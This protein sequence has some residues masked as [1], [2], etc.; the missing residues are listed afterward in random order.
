MP[1]TWRTVRVFISST[2]RDMYGEREEL[3]K[4]VFPQ[5]RK[6]CEQRGV[7]WGEVDLRWGV[8][9]E[10]KAEGKVLPICLEE[11][12]RCRPY[13]IGIL[14]EHYGWIPDEIPQDVSRRE[15][16][17][18]QHLHHSVT[19]LEILH[20]VLNNPEMAKHAFFYFRDAEASREVEAELAKNPDYQPESEDSQAK[21][22]TLKEKIEK[23][24]FPVRKDFRD[25][26]V[27]GELI[28]KDLTAVIDRLYPAD[29]APDTLDR[30]VMEHEAYADRLT[31]V[32]IERKGY[33][34][35]LNKHVSGSGAPLVVL[36]ESGVG[37]SA[38]LANWALKYRE[39]LNNKNAS[40]RKPLLLM[41]FIGASPYSTDWA[42]MLRRIM[43]ELKRHFNIRE[44]IPDK[45]D[46]LRTAF[47]N[48]LHMAAAKGR[49]ILILDALNQLEDRDGAPD[50]VWLPPHIPENIRLILTTLPG[51]P[52]DDLQK[53]GWPTLEVSPLDRDERET[54]IKQY[55]GQYTKSLSQAQVE[56]IA[57]VPQTANPLYLRSLLEE[58]RVYGDHATLNKRI[59]HYLTADTISDLYSR[60]LRR[61][62]EDYEEERPGL[63]KDAMSLLW[64]ARRGLSES[65]LME[66]LGTEEMPLPRATW[67]PLFLAA[68]Q[69]LVSRS[70]LITFGHDY[71]RQ[72]VQN[73]FLRNPGEQ[74]AAHTRLA[75]YYEKQELGPRKVDEL[76]WQLVQVKSWKRLY[77][78][79][80]HVAFVF[81]ALAR[82]NDGYNEALKYW[83][84][85]ENN[86]PLRMIDGYKNAIRDSGSLAESVA[87]HDYL[88]CIS[89]LLISFGYYREAIQIQEKIVEYSHIND[90]KKGL[91]SSLNNI[92]QYY[93]TLAELD[94][95]WSLIEEAYSVCREL[96]DQHG[97][98]MALNTKAQI[99][100]RRGKLDEALKLLEEA[101]H[102]CSREGMP[103]GLARTLL[104]Q[105]NIL[106]DKRN[107]EESL[108]IYRRAEQ[109]YLGTGNYGGVAACI[110]N[111]A[112][113][114]T[115]KKEYDNAIR[116][117][118]KEEK[119]FREIG[120]RKHLYISLRLQAAC[121]KEK[122]DIPKAISLLQ[123]SE[124]ICEQ[125]GDNQGLADTLLEEAVLFVQKLDKPE[126]ALPLI[127]KGQKIG[128][129]LNNSSLQTRY[130]RLAEYLS[131]IGI[132]V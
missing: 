106:G 78:L 39:S 96:G 104:N 124:Q 46:A 14:G 44:E 48:W 42:V 126:L 71:L 70:G 81:S 59:G 34:D 82:S 107:F 88:T 75:D 97:Q 51:R 72:A 76:P 50:L 10:Q 19:E 112:K 119:I 121:V 57:V 83:V 47:A 11:I 117:H 1:Q 56:R 33:F 36:G 35:T 37:K 65:E 52:L 80:T 98:E 85:V 54:L 73:T 116:L 40:R 91:A 49:V 77:D 29:S 103:D 68:E 9:D 7:T 115:G 64:A 86:S 30:E 18:V 129:S 108:N 93:Y 66:L 26:K 118:R 114:L 15:P 25:S 125:L 63:V 41:H 74:Q 111:Q 20:G 13:F 131:M 22:K 102:I 17:L 24:G 123:E 122:G 31:L 99:L 109:I 84:E 23:S 43:G 79:L 8:T 90:D 128:R 55:L 61:Y 69:S 87:V 94:K 100:R 89:S 12:Q 32:Y 110:G 105:A 62:E 3:V 2:F 60:I 120:E 6:L 21:L 92:A 130:Q 45:P 53:R 58:L 67:S 127:K 101:E 16:W 4:R 27:L 28:L 132:D 95:A 5:L 113:I 38:L